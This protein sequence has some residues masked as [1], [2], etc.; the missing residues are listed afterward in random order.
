[1]AKRKSNKQVKQ[2][3]IDV[4]RYISIS[5]GNDFNDRLFITWFDG[6]CLIAGANF[7]WLSTGVVSIKVSQLRG[8]S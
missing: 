1:M 6:P 8:E 4:E 7:L 2:M 3:M 5:M